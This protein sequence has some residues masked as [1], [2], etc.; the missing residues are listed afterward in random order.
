VKIKIKKPW[1]AEAAHGFWL[2]SLYQFTAGLRANLSFLFVPPPPPI[3]KEL[4]AHETF[5]LKR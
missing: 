4:F 1:T 2:F 5:S 3:G